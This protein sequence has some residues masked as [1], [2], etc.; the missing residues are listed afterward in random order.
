MLGRLTGRGGLGHRALCGRPGHGACRGPCFSRARTG[1]RRDPDA[2]TRAILP[3]G[4]EGGRHPLDPA[5]GAHPAAVRLP[6][7]PG[8]RRPPRRGGRRR[9]RGPG[10]GRRA[11]RRRRAGHRG[12]RGPGD[13]AGASGGRGP[14]HRGA[15]RVRPWRPG[16]R[17]PVRGRLRRPRGPGRRV[18][19]G[20][21][22]RRA[23]QRGRRHRPLRL[24]RARGGAARRP[25]HRRVHRRP[26]ARARQPPA[27][28]AGGALRAGVGGAGRAAGRGA[29]ADPAPA[30]RPRRAVAALAPRAGAGGAR[31]AGARGPR[32]A[33]AGTAAG[34]PGRPG[35][36]RPHGPGGPRGGAP[37]SQAQVR[38]DR[39]SGTVYLVGAGP[40]DPGLLT[41][42]GA[43]VLGRAD[44][45]VYDRLAPPELLRLAPPGAELVDAGKTPGGQGPDQEAINR[46][47]VGRAAAGRTVVRLKG[48]DPFVFGRGGEEALACVRAGAPL[49]VVP[50]VSA[51]LAA[52]AYAGVPL[53]QRDLAAGFAV[54]TASLAGGRA[55]ELDRAAGAADTLVVLMPAEPAVV[56][57]WAATARQR[58]VRATLDDLPALA[59]ATGIGPPATLVVGRVAA[60]ADLLAW[61]GAGS[62]DGVDETGET[63]GAGRVLDTE[64]ARP[65]R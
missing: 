44:V 14:R 63:A 7:Q 46:L 11:A 24:R 22:R 25:R 20:P 62:P 21:R 16:R 10:Q 58:S 42:R 43:E 31:G 26:H 45:V 12:R 15:A 60:L 18:R 29:R 37:V 23:G 59:A 53:T 40:G 9:R 39:T 30:A 49:E 33:G 50:G 56:V 55:A 19:R 57:Q 27:P 35:A 64:S 8:P 4:A 51:A 1:A 61:R 52:P 41:L 47:L 48:G 5:D 65:A 13:R 38:Q 2:C 28:P 3:E 34:P 6:R 54:V 36:G 17:V 32:R